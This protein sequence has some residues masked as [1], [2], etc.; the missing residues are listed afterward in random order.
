MEKSKNNK[1]NNISLAKQQFIADLKDDIDFAMFKRKCI[2]DN[3]LSYGVVTASANT[4]ILNAVGDT[5][6]T[7]VANHFKNIS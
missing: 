7:L 1:V 2:M 3:F 5:C 6:E 4:F